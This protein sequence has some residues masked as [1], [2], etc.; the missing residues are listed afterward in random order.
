MRF[1]KVVFYIAGIYGLVSVPPLYFLFDVIGR[2]DPPAITHP[3]FY[4]GFVGVALAWQFA[5]LVIA[6]NPVRFRPL[7]IPS[8]VEK[9]SYVIAVAVL[10]SQGKMSGQQSLTAVP[11]LLLGSL[12]I[13]S[14]LKTPRA[15]GGD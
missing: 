10:Y 8:V 15:A 9:L 12:F 3:Q 1:A 2:R 14:F 11:D 13:L 7:M 6:T 4:Y 5:F